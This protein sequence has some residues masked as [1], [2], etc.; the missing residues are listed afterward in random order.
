MKR[1]KNN[2]KKVQEENNNNKTNRL[3]LFP[4][5]LCEVVEYHFI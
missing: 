1:T 4:P 5:I 3:S 2:M